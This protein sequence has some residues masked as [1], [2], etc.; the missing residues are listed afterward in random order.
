MFTSTARL[1]SQLR[2]AFSGRRT[3]PAR[4]RRRSGCRPIMDILEDRTVP[5]T[6]TIHLTDSTAT[7]V[8]QTHYLDKTAVYAYANGLP[9]G[10][11][12]VEVV[13]PGGKNGDPADQLGVSLASA[14]IHVTGGHFDAGFP[15]GPVLPGTA[16]G[17]RGT[18]FNVW[19]E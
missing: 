17:P 9:D 7:I 15:T 1:V 14:P 2:R 3:P 5:S 12:D 16:T 19:D 6:G 18:A 8:E 11:Y 13:A 4:T 10:Y